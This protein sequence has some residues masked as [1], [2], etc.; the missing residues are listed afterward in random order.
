[1]PYFRI[2]CFLLL[3]ICASHLAGHFFLLP[4]FKLTENLTGQIPAND[5]E[6]H[7]LALMNS[8]KK[9]VG[10]TPVSMMDIQNGLSLAYSLFF[11][12]LGSLNLLLYKPIRRNHRLLSRISY[13]NACMLFLGAIISAIYF[14]WLPIASFAAT[15]VLFLLAGH[16]FGKSGQF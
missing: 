4:H 6:R 2:A 10:G 12:W 15:M 8:Y 11:L 9:M 3:F 7:L 14:F 5:T 1:M 13:L 16:T